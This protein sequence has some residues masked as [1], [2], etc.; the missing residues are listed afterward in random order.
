[1][2]RS[3]QSSQPGPENL[4]LDQRGAGELGRG[5]A[6]AWTVPSLR[7]TPTTCLLGS[8]AREGSGERVPC[9]R[10]SRLGLV[11]FMAGLPRSL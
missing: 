9:T 2:R 11:T 5:P 3:H 6:T 10:G 1:M 4:P 8:C 7:I